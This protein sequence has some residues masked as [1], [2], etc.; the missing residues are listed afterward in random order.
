MSSNREF[1]VRM[2]EMYKEHPCLWKTTDQDYHNRNRRSE[3]YESTL[4]LFK[5]N[6]PNA[7]KEMVLKKNK[8]DARFLPKRT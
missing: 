7:T 8:L 3:A 2:I 6:D 4:Q 5:T 1:V